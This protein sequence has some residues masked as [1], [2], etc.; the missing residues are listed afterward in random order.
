M[1][2]LR[3]AILPLSRLLPVPPMNVLSIQSA[4]AYGH[5]GNAAAQPALHRLGHTVWRVDTVAFSNH[6]G[7][8][9]FAGQVRPA[10]EVAAVLQ[11]LAN[12]GVYRECAAVLSGYLGEAETASTVAD[13]VTQVKRL[14]PQAVYLLDPVMGDAGRVYVRDGVPAAMAGM[15]LP[16]ADIVAPNAFELSLLAD[17]P[18]SDMATAVAAARVL[19]ARSVGLGPSLVLATGLRLEGGRVAT[20]AVTHAEAHAVT[21]PWIDR[22]IFGTGDLFGALFLGHWLEA[23]G[24]AVHAL[25]LAA[26]GMAEAVAATDAANSSELVLIPNLERI[27]QPPVLLPAERV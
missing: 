19:L 16:L 14:N 5:V 22:P 24:D 18:V 21:A 6:P 4:V 26:S 23:P 27:C 10:A 8:G 20:L 9:K 17:R 3:P 25:R 1:A 15:L 13:A 11:G 12:L 7:H 2:S